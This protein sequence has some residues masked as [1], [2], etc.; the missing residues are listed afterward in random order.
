MDDIFGL[1]VIIIIPFVLGAILLGV[2]AY[3]NNTPEHKAREELKSELER[4]EIERIKR[5]LR[6]KK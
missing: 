5:E 6:N 3:Y 4:K 1:C 2:C